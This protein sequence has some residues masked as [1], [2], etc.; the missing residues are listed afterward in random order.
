VVTVPPSVTVAAG[1]LTASFPVTTQ[2]QGQATITASFNSTS[3][4]A[5]VVVTAPEVESLTVAPAA[6]TAFAGE[7]V[8]FTATGLF[9]DGSSQ[10]LANDIT[11]SSTN[12]SVASIGSSGLATALTV[13]TTTIRATVTTSVGPV[14]GETTLTVQPAPALVVTPLTTSL[15]V[16]QSA[17]FTVGTAVAPTSALTVT[18]AISGSGTALLSPVSVVISAG[19]TTSPTPVQVTATGIGSVILTATAPVRQPASSTLTI[20]AGLPVITSVSPVSGVIG[21]V[22]TLS[23]SSFNPVAANNQ[24]RFGGVLATVL[25]VSTTGSSLTTAV[26]VGALTGPVTVT[27]P[28]GIATSPVPFTLLNSAPVLSPIGNKTLSLGSTL[29]FTVSGVDPNG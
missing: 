27:T 4:T 6:P 14:T 18:L 24:V 28:L 17:L 13:G 25:S 8:A 20:T 11:W 29:A 15:T 2:T 7:S 16:G 23:G 1:Q 21:S 26:P 10:P 19:Q 5:Q 12:Q 9:T 22:V 3:A